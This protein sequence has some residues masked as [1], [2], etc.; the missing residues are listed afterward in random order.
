MAGDGTS[1]AAMNSETCNF[2]EPR[3]LAGLSNPPRSPEKCFLE[4]QADELILDS[5]LAKSPFVFPVQA[6]HNALETLG[7]IGI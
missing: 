4:N 3:A 6:Q 5:S 7:E 1:N 2:Q